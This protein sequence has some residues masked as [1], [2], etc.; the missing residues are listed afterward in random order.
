MF[1]PYLNVEMISQRINT[2]VVDTDKHHLM[3]Y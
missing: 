3:R 1:A 2:A